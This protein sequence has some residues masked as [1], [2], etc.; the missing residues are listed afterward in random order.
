M[1]LE[2]EFV[3]AIDKL[4]PDF[5]KEGFKSI[6]TYLAKGNRVRVIK[7]RGVISNGLV[8]ELEKLNKI[9]DYSI[10]SESESFTEWGKMKICHKWLPPSRNSGS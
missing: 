2:D 1:A 9:L 10:V 4:S 8:I 7:L 3:L 5:G 6:S